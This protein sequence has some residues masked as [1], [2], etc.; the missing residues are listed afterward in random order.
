M[1]RAL[2]T[3]SLVSGLSLVAACGPQ[4]AEDLTITP[5]ADVE[6]NLP[7]VPTLVPPPHPVQY[8]DS[9]YSIYG[10]RHRRANTTNTE[11]D[12]TGWIVDVYVPPECEEEDDC[13]P[14]T[15]PHMW[16]AD[17]AGETESGNRL[18]VVGYAENQL[19]LDEA[20]EAMESGNPIEID[21]EL[22]ILPVPTDFNIGA[23]VKIH[24]RFAR[25]S[26]SGFN[27]STGLLE[28]RSHETLEPAP[29]TEE[30]DDS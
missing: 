21:P 28:Y 27:I 6:P 25:I 9:S 7:S 18:T 23:K 26:G 19:Q 29:G 10:V 12:I 5:L 20:I 1:V 16:I 14:A 13:P 17:T 30:D 2:I 11:V 24:G 22:G 15:A 3:L 8:P 4:A